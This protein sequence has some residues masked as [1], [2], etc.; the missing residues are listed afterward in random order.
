MDEKKFNEN[1]DKAFTKFQQSKKF[2]KKYGAETSDEKK[3]K[4]C[5]ENIRKY[6]FFI[7]KLMV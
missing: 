6:D 2:K 1:W 4:T 7:L 3:L 5:K